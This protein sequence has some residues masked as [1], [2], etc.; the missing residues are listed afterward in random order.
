MDLNKES[1]K[2]EQITS[3]KSWIARKKSSLPIL[4]KDDYDYRLVNGQKELLIELNNFLNEEIT[5]LQNNVT[6]S[7]T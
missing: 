6:E 3:V 7:K 5:T 4:Q 2:L 1:N